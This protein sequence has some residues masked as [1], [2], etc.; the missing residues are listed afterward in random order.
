MNFSNDIY[1]AN[2]TEDI[3]LNR[4]EWRKIMYQRQGYSSVRT[5]QQRHDTY[6]GVLR[7]SMECPFH[8]SVVSDVWTQSHL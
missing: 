5:L 1:F 4:A 3:A 2:V 6:F 7:V 8:A